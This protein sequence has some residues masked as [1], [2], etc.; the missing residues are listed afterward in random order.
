M[1]IAIGI[2]ITMSTICILNFPSHHITKRTSC[3]ILCSDFIW[4]LGSQE[5]T[6]ISIFYGL[7]FF[8]IYIFAYNQNCDISF[9]F[10]FFHDKWENFDDPNSCLSFE[11]TMAHAPTTSFLLLHLLLYSI[12]IVDLL[13]RIY[14]IWKHY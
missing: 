12:N 2:G 7:Y 8:R 3:S 1:S 14:K 5:P 4:T 10:I 13:L 11:E 6:K 9:G